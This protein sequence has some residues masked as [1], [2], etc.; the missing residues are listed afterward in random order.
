MEPRIQYA[1]TKDE[2]SIAIVAGSSQSLART[3]VRE[4][5]RLGR[6]TG[7]YSNVEMV[8]LS[9]MRGLASARNCRHGHQGHS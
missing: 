4:V 2:V 8:L 7:S 1:Q 3:W 6:K 9:E 5:F